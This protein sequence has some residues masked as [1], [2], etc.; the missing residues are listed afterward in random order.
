MRPARQ[1]VLRS[2]HLPA[3]VELAREAEREWRARLKRA[4]HEANA[5]LPLPLGPVSFVL[6]GKPQPKERARACK[7]GKHRTPKPTRQYEAAIKATAALHLGEWRK[8]GVFRLR[9]HAVFGDYRRRDA[10]NV[11]KA[12]QDGLNEVA[13]WDDHQVAEPV[14]TME[15]IPGQWRTI[16]TIERLGDAPARAGRQ[17]SP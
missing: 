13:Y 16:V 2:Q 6:E 15:V 5:R 14:P 3:P 10:D 9:V 1:Q 7:D 17:A 12:V 8:D 11:L 4:Q